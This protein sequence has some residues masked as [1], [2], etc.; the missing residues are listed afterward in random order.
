MLLAFVTCPLTNQATPF[1]SGWGIRNLTVGGFRQHEFS[2]TNADDEH[3]LLRNTS[4][5]AMYIFA[6]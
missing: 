5:R 6:K 3:S 1:C 4:R 2:K